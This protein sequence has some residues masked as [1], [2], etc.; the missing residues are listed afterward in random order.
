MAESSAPPATRRKTEY[1]AGGYVC[2]SV[3]ESNEI[4]GEIWKKVPDSLAPGNNT[5]VSNF[6]RVRAS[7]GA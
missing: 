2:E 6:G 4:E 3:E 1:T 5:Y 7:S